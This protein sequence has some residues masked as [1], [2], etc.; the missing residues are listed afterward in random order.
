MLILNLQPHAVEYLSGKSSST[1]HYLANEPQDSV[2]NI[3]S[4]DDKHVNIEGRTANLATLSATA[5]LEEIY[6]PSVSGCGSGVSY[7]L[8]SARW[9]GG[10]TE[11]GFS[12]LIEV[13]VVES[14]SDGWEIKVKFSEPLTE[15]S[16][17]SRPYI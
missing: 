14:F 1:V 11:A 5:I 3:E 4:V 6:H 12:A 9:S 13:P 17:V 2:Y 16:L 8:T 7:T 10:N 15:F